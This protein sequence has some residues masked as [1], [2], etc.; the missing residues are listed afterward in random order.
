VMKFN[1]IFFLIAILSLGITAGCGGGST[2]STSGSSSGGSGGT[3]A[4]NNVATLTVDQGPTALL[5]TGQADEDMAFVT[6]TVCV[7]GTT[8][9]QDIDHVQVDTG[10]EGLRI[11]SGILTKVSLQ[12]Q[13]SG[14]NPV[15]ECAQFGDLTFLWGT[16]ATADIQISGEVAKNVPIQIADSSVA[17]SSCSSGETGQ[18]VT[19]ADLGSNAIL[20]LGLFRQDCGFGCTQGAPP[21]FYYS[22]SNG[23]C[24]SISEPLTAQLQNPVWMFPGDNNGVILQLPSVPDVGQATVANGQLIFGIGTQSNNG[25][26]SAV[27]LP[28]DQ[29]TGNFA[30]QFAGVTYNDFN[31][32]GSGGGSSFIDSGSN[33]YFFLD[34]ATLVNAGFPIPDCPSSANLQ[35]FY[36]PSPTQPIS[37]TVI[38][39]N[40][41]GIPAGPS[42]TI[43]F[44]V[45]DAQTLF[46]SGFSAF[47][48]VG[49]DNSNSFDFGLPFIFGKS[50]FFVIEGQTTPAGTGPFYAF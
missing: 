29:N 14:T 13:M 47:N 6:I 2:G 20:G 28:V 26:G 45:A 3:T 40:S 8:A 7:P 31:G 32:P 37:V 11:A 49:G 30:A 19:P 23:A 36:C 17:P 15:S 4:A 12:T 41:S 46:Q 10:S 22:C 50:V 9:C 42:R 34:S 1:R 39:D 33:G 5:V 18:L 48:N 25:L 27:A 24:S 16:V 44:N 43:N 38:G 21:A 35:G